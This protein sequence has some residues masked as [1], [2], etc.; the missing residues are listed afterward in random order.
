MVG[1]VGEHGAGFVLGRPGREGGVEGVAV[2]APCAG[3]GE[4]GVGEGCWGNVVEWGHVDF[5][6]FAHEAVEDAQ[7][8]DF[9]F[10]ELAPFVAVDPFD[11]VEQEES[12]HVE[13]V[14]V[15]DFVLADVVPV[16]VVEA[17]EGFGGACAA[18]TVVVELGQDDGC[19]GVAL[20][21]RVAGRA[22][23]LE[24][25]GEQMGDLQGR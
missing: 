12:E 5:H 18:G 2:G 14:V 22:G 10:G 7:A 17:G 13:H 6:G 3:W 1:R 25:L 9:E 4:G 8:G 11:G 20:T 15:G 24:G 19:V 16:E 21:N 23:E